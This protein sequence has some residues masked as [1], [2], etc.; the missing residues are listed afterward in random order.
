MPP[1]AVEWLVRATGNDCMP[2]S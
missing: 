2:R 1:L